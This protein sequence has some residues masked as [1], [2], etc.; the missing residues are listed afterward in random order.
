MAVIVSL[1]RAGSSVSDATVNLHTMES[2]YDPITDSR[3]S[4]STAIPLQVDPI[5]LPDLTDTLRQG[6]KRLAGTGSFSTVYRCLYAQNGEVS[7][8]AL[9]LGSGFTHS[10]CLQVAVKAISFSRSFD[11]SDKDEFLR[12]R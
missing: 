1:F 8:S 11:K 5:G 3:Y 10:L 9:T 2:A 4:S 6:S 12:V 7:M